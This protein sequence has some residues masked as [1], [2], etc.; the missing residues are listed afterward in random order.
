MKLSLFLISLS[1]VLAGP[2][3]KA[4]A[5]AEPVTP[6]ATPATLS[7]TGLFAP[8]NLVAWCVVPFDAKKRGPE[9]RAAMLAGLGIKRLAYDWREEHVPTFDEEVEAMRR[10]GIE[11]TAWWF[12]G[13]LD[14]TARE[15]LAV[16]RR[17]KIAPQLWVMGGGGPVKDE[18]G[19][20][21]QVMQQAANLRPIAVAAAEAGC[22]IALY[23]HGG[24]F[25]EPE[26]QVEI[27][28]QLRREG[29]TNAGIVYNFHHGHDHV[30]RFPEMLKK[31]QPHL[32]AVNLNGMDPGG[33]RVGRKILH[34]GEGSDELELMRVLRDSGWR[35]PVGV[36][37][38]RPETDTEQTLQ[39][40]LKGL[41]W[42]RKELVEAGSGGSRPFAGGAGALV[43]GKFGQALDAGIRG[44]VKPAHPSWR[45]VPLTVELW[46]RLR[47]RAQFNILT[48]SE[49]KSSATHWELYT[50][51]G[52]GDLSIYL[53]GRGG[54]FRTGVNICDDQWHHL[55]A[56]IE[57]SKV[58]LYVDG[59]LIKQAALTQPEGAPQSGGLGIGTL[60]EGGMGC[61]GMID[62]VRLL[63]VP[64]PPEALP[65]APADRDETTTGLWHFD[66]VADLGAAAFH[67]RRAPLN[68]A[69]RPLHRHPVNRDRVYDFYA[70][71]AI[72]AKSQ[73]PLP[74]RLASYPGLDGGQL[75]H[76]G[77]QNE[78]T[79][80][81]DA[82]AMMDVGSV[83]AGV[84]RG[85]GLTV[86]RAVCVKLPGQGGMS[87]GARLL[88]ELIS[89]IK[90]PDDRPQPGEKSH[91]RR[92]HIGFGKAEK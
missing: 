41:E 45:G 6:A 77:N 46:T 1:G 92:Q 11:M 65:A 67:P 23:N 71:Q 24:W 27:I 8:E 34:L 19:Q 15:I 16:I 56:V 79:W 86:P 37:D 31:M 57:E 54:D 43:P 48:A 35:G 17:Q 52:T 80:Q 53:P 50:H 44:V 32:L 9:E 29:I 90:A 21:T 22:K 78:K 7:A 64:R 70:K 60:V 33:D 69:D 3:N 51:A 39:K 84:F 30:E 61:D 66:E 62:E 83:Q 91:L 13:S 59:K 26:N 36:I 42:L 2:L 28:E 75:G 63:H 18:A 25:G 12:P 76:W 14:A 47:S 20:K 68:P 89:Q 40:N 85:W 73:N 58:R 81:G 87:G 74:E 49:P 82:W 55:S 10:H 4:V 72:H 38:H 5:Q 88:A